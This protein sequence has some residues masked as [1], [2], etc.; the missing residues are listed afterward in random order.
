MSEQLGD[1]IAAAEN[2]RDNADKAIG[3]FVR[4]GRIDS[5]SLSAVNESMAAVRIHLAEAA[6]LVAALP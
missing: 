2:A 5:V 4:S 3:K 6:K 1:V